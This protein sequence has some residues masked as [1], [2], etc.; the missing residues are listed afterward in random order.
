VNA[1]V[2]LE[3]DG[4]DPFTIANVNSTDPTRDIIYTLP[5]GTKGRRAR[6]RATPGNGGKFQ[7]WDWTC[8]T[9]PADKGPVLHTND[10]DDLGY[11]HDKRLKAV[12]VQ[13]EVTQEAVMNLYFLQG[14]GASQAANPV[15]VGIPLHIGGRK[16]ETYRLSGQ[17][18]KAMRF[19]P[20]ATNTLFK[21][22]S[23]KFEYDELPPDFVSET[24]WEDYGYPYE[25]ILQQLA[26]EMDTGGQPCSIDV[27]TDM[28]TPGVQTTLQIT[29]T[30]GDLVRL[31]TFPVASLAVPVM[32]KR[33]KLVFRPAANGKAQLYSYYM[34]WLRANP[35]PVEHSSAWDSVEHPY[36]KRFSEVTIE[37]DAN[38]TAGTQVALD[39]ITGLHGDQ[40]NLQAATFT[41]AGAGHGLQTFAI[42]PEVIA[43]MVRLRPVSIPIT[44]FRMWKYRFT[45]F[46]FP[47]DIVVA[48]EW[49][50][51]GWPYEKIL[52]TLTLDVDTGGVPAQVDVQADGGGLRTIEVNTTAENRSFVT[53]MVSDLIGKRF[54]L[55]AVPG[56]GG[57]FQLF[58]YK[59]DAHREPPQ[60]MRHE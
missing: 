16:I 35:G 7:L 55:R 41:L 19:Q 33:F 1:S 26:I 39:T 11:P 56:P 9:A 15:P 30:E 59:F 43:K 28:D 8:I 48:T 36:D 37:Y 23:Y 52:K 3:V 60:L 6:L 10:W 49:V 29:T 47:P 27:V 40:I 42:Q 13:Y 4:A 50:D 44:D 45:K 46:D 57:K 14:F 22:W 25:K 34:H 21:S 38:G 54:R 32:A 17:I 2:T 18:A 20:V 24:K 53:S 12:T 31:L 51:L 58:D 5:A